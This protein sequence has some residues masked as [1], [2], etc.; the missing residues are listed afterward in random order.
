VPYNSSPHGVRPG[1]YRV[2]ITKPGEK[3]PAKYN[4]EAILGQEVVID[5]KGIEESPKSASRD[6]I[7]LQLEY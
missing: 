5:A 1:F 3:I 6:A 7:S 2:E 4:T